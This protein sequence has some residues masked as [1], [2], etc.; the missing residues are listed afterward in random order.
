MSPRIR[1]SGRGKNATCFVSGKSLFTFAATVPGFVNVTPS[2]IF[3]S[4]LIDIS[5]AYEFYRFTK[6][7]FR[8]L[9]C[10]FCNS[11]PAI[12]TLWACGYIPEEAKSGATPSTNAIFELEDSCSFA[13]PCTYSTAILQPQTV[14]SSWAKVSRSSLL[15]TPTRWFKTSE[16]N[17]EDAF[18]VQGQIWYNNTSGDNGN[19]SLEVTWNCE[20]KGVQPLP[21]Q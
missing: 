18:V 9:P 1:H 10:S 15:S 16:V 13:P 3:S 11:P 12:G 7:H 14:P 19:L 20:F 8:I 17:P 4:R 6:L 21:F 2:A 5:E